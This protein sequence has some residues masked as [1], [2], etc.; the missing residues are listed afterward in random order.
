MIYSL[1]HDSLMY[2]AQPLTATDSYGRAVNE[3]TSSQLD[4]V[5]SIASNVHLHT[6][7]EVA[8]ML[9][10][11]ATDGECTNKERPRNRLLHF[12]YLHH[13]QTHLKD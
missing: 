6:T 9:L 12:L 8:S 5:T 11:A 4:L 3:P 2:N 10:P 7:D 1:Y 13:S